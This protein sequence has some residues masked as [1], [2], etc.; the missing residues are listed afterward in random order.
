MNITWVG[1]GL[2]AV[3]ILLVLL[4]ARMV[5]NSKRREIRHRANEETFSFTDMTID[6][7]PVR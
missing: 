1:V 6:C 2:G 3:V 4:L 5:A 7:G